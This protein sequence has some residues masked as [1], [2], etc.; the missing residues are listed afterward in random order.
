MRHGAAS[1]DDIDPTDTEKLTEFFEKANE[2]LQHW[3][4]D[5]HL[6]NKHLCELVTKDNPNGFISLAPQ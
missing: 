1:R 3:F 4:E 2:Q 5:K 6:N